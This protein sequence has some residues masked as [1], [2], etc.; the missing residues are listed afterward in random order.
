MI[1]PPPRSLPGG[2][3]LNQRKTHKMDE[4]DLPPE[5][6]SEDKLE[7]LNS[8]MEEAVGLIEMINQMEEDLKGFK[9][10]LRTIQFSKIPDMLDELEIPEISFKNYK[11][12]VADVIEGTLAKDP[13]KRAKALAWVEAHG[14]EGLIQTQ[15]G[16]TFGK[17]QHEEAKALA[18]SLEAQGLAIEMTSG[19]HASTYKAWAR[20]RMRNGETLDEDALGLYIARMAEIK[21]VKVKK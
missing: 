6:P 2:N 17:S 4:F 8:A 16:L 9:S 18:E 13:E 7:A 3:F 12:K 21:P 14:G 10:R 5:D 1:L 19:I 15:I 20:E 11:I